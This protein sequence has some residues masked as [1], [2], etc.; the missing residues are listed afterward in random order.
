MRLS[1]RTNTIILWIISIGLMIGMVIMFTPTLGGMGGTPGGD[2]GP[3]VLR[4]NGEPVSELEIAQA[5]QSSPIYNMV[6]EGPVAEDLELLLVDGV[7]RQEVV[8]QAAARHRVTNADVR[9]ELAAFRE[10]NG[11]DGARNDQAYLRLIG[12]AGYTDQTFRDYL[13]QQLQVSAYQ[14]EI[15]GDVEVSDAE[16]ESFYRVNQNAYRS[17]PRV[18]ARQIVTEDRETAEEA[19]ERVLAGESF[20]EVAAEVSIER[21]EQGGALG[22]DEPQ[23]VGRPAFPTAVADEVFALSA[24]GVTP[25]V[26]S[27]GR[28]YLASVEEIVP[29]EPR[30]L[31]DVRE[32]VREDALAAKQQAALEQEIDRLRQEAEVEVVGDADLSLANPPVARV[33][34]EEIHSAELVRA[35]YTN[36][37]I[38]QA[39]SPQTASLI[40]EFFKPSVLEQLVDRELAVQGAEELDATFFGGDALVAQSALD[41]VARDAEASEEEIQAF[42]EANQDRYTVAAS[43]EVRRVEFADEAAASAFRSAILAGA[44]PEEAAEDA[45]ADLEDL[46]TVDPGTLEPALDAA[47]FDADG[48][49]PAP[50]AEGDVSDVLLVERE[51]EEP[52]EEGD[53]DAAAANQEAAAEGD[54]PPADDAG[55]ESAV[56]ED[57]PPAPATEQ[58]YVVLIAERTPQRVRPLEEVRSDVEQTV[59]SQERQRLQREWLDARRAD[60]EVEILLAS[61]EPAG[62]ADG[63]PE[64]AEGAA[65]ELEGV[66]LDVAV[67][68]DA[69]PADGDAP[70][71]PAT[72]AEG[73]APAEDDAPDEAE[74]AAE[75]EAPADGDGEDAAE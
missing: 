40:S 6:D 36:P 63:P 43:A 53:A 62:A 74:A 58:V 35:T 3:T 15:T 28:F 25:V 9:Q 50:E 44:T 38:Q 48:F 19:R 24:P 21:A 71:Q 8:R 39:L 42:Y 51:V 45:G 47:L 64:G 2:T 30:P 12:G 32:Q 65:A 55:E 18:V 73:D 23:A 22:G 14:E 11:V 59:L 61:A 7:V 16:V 27:G 1:R 10:R 66:E 26:E 67:G 54:D 75:A 68:D 5:R 49:E 69:A 41:Y 33:G 72:P 37:Q 17:D 4:V 13:R 60:T 31:D 57:A 70:A 20:A 56:D 52:T 29:A 46:G 34:D